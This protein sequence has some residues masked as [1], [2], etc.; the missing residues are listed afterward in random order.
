MKSLMKKSSLIG[1]AAPQVG[2]PFQIFIIHFPKPSHFFSKEE[3]M[4]KGMEHVNEQVS[5]KSNYKISS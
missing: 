4:L 5:L 2:I 1:L 3:I